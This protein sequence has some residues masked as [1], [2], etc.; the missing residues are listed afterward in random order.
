M[1]HMIYTIEMICVYKT[2]I[3][4]YLHNKDKN[5]KFINYINQKSKSNFKY[6]LLNE[7]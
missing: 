3:P 1:V 2:L 4:I 7:N 5:L 6:I